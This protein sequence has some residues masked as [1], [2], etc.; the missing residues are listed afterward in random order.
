[1]PLYAGYICWQAMWEKG[2]AGMAGYVERAG[3][4][5]DT[6]LA[7]FLELGRMKEQAA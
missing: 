6:V 3:F 4:R 7:D 2:E 1:M 5:V